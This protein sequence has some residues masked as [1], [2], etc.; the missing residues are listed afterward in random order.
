MREILRPVALEVNVRV[1]QS[2]TLP[3]LLDKIGDQNVFVFEEVA[4]RFGY[5]EFKHLQRKSFEYVLN[6]QDVLGASLLFPLGSE[7]HVTRSP[8][9][10]ARETRRC[11]RIGQ[12]DGLID[13]KEKPLLSPDL[14][15]GCMVGKGN[16]DKIFHK[17]KGNYFIILNCV[18]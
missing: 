9:F 6:E 1:K 11:S 13:Q 2:Q 8:E 10:S 18:T 15:N 5:S 4:K 17:D 16:K 7:F 3:T 14:V 12:S